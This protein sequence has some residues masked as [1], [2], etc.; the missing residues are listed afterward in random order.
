MWVLRNPKSQSWSRDLSASLKTQWAKRAPKN[1]LQTFLE[2]VHAFLH[3]AGGGQRPHHPGWDSSIPPPPPPL[4]QLFLSLAFASWLPLRGK[5]RPLLACLVPLCSPST[6]VTSPITLLYLGAGCC[7][8][9]YI[10]TIS[11]PQLLPRW[12]AILSCCSLLLRSRVLMRVLRLLSQMVCL[13]MLASP[14]AGDAC[15]R[16]P[17][18]LLTGTFHTAFW[19]K[20][21]N[22]GS[23]GGALWGCTITCHAGPTIL[24]FRL[25]SA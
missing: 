9:S 6:W 1:R 20:Q 24:Y 16:I 7:D 8:I 2:S 12:S 25:L 14:P 5:C 23:N 21:W 11:C 18:M 22:P 17:Q 19:T 15:R 3:L 10:P 4:L 13:W